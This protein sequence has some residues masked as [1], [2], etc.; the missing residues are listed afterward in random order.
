MK[1]MNILIVFHIALLLSFCS[2]CIGLSSSN[3]EARILAK[4]IKMLTKSVANASYLTVMSCWNPGNLS[5]RFGIVVYYL[6][7][8]T[9]EFS[10]HFYMS[11]NDINNTTGNQIIV[12][13]LDSV[14]QLVLAN[15]YNEF[16][17]IDFGCD[18]SADILMNAKEMLMNHF[19]L[20]L[21][22]E[23]NVVCTFFIQIY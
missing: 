2:K 22:M 5:I 18:S 21:D 6:A 11:F 23:S 16:I 10:F 14:N 17:L 8:N 1:A 4:S 7:H 13:H 12:T 3:E 9:A 20:I 15:E 19:W